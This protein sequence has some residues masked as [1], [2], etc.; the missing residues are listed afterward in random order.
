MEKFRYYCNC[1]NWDSSDLEGLESIV[2]NSTEITYHEMLEEVSLE[3]LH[4]IFPFYEDCP[5][6]MEKDWSVRYHRSEYN[7][8]PCVYVLH[9]AIEYVFV[10]CDY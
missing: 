10:P 8:K 1:V 7:G 4:D 6:T 9:S 3:Q 5:L 2:D